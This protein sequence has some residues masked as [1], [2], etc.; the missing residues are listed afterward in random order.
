LGKN[1]KKIRRLKLGK[2]SEDDIDFSKS[3]CSNFPDALNTSFYHN[4]S[5]IFDTDKDSYY[6]KYCILSIQDID[7]VVFKAQH[8]LYILKLVRQDE[9]IELTELNFMD[10]EDK[11]ENY[12]LQRIEYVNNAYTQSELPKEFIN[13]VLEKDLKFITFQVNLKT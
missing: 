6:L 12:S 5:V 2:Y 8:I 10:I 3:S 1:G 4:S 13:I 9:E 11:Y 7:I